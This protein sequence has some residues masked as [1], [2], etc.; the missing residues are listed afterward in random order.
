[1]NKLENELVKGEK[2]LAKAEYSNTPIIVFGIINVLCLLIHPVLALL[3]LL[4]I[5]RSALVAFFTSELMITNKRIYGVSGLIK[6]E[7]IDY[8]LRSINKFAINNTLFGGILGY[9]K[10]SI[11]SHGEGWQLNY[12]KNA[13]QLKKVFYEVKEEE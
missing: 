6:K 12:V 1:M 10:L 7:E 9:K 4:L 8:T 11:S 3:F 5:Y 2:V 13:K